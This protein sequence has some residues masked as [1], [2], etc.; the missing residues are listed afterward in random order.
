MIIIYVKEYSFYIK[1][2]SKKYRIGLNNID[3]TIN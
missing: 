1:Y 3:K 2:K